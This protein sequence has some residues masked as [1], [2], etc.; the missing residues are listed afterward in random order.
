VTLYLDNSLLNRPFD[1]PSI[2]MNKLEGEILLLIIQLAEK[3]NIQFVHSAVIAYENSVNPFPERKAF[4]EEVMK[5]AASYQNIDHAVYERAAAI[6]HKCNIKPLDALHI[7][8]A[9]AAQVDLF[10][11]C[12]YNLP[13]RYQD[14]LRT[15][16]PIEF[17]TYYENNN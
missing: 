4:V 14:G 12:D 8:T 9:E 15:V 6:I 11:T 5:L 2:M 7:A 16:T 13:K 17:L 10:I 1:N 3:G